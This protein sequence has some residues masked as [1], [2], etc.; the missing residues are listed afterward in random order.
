MVSRDRETADGTRRTRGVGRDVWS[1]PQ[2]VRDSVTVGDGVR[3]QP[4]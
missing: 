1:Q 4:Q 2:R 3:A